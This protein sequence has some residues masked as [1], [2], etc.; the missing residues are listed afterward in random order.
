MCCLG[1]AKSHRERLSHLLGLPKLGGGSYYPV[2]EK[3][4]L[5]VKGEARGYV[6]F[7]VEEESYICKEASF[8]FS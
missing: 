6:G 4:V 2:L 5:G 1:V 8:P 7:G 3:W